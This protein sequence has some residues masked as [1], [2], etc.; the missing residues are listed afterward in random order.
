MRLFLSILFIILIV[1]C[2]ADISGISN[3]GVYWMIYIITV[4]P[5]IV[6]ICNIIIF[7]KT[8]KKQISNKYFFWITQVLS[9]LLVLASLETLKDSY[10][11]EYYSEGYLFTFFSLVILPL[12]F[13]AY[14]LYF[15]LFKNFKFPAKTKY[16]VLA[17]IALG[18]SLSSIIK[19][20]YNCVGQGINL[21]YTGNPFVFKIKYPNDSL[22][23]YY[24][25]VGVALNLVVWVGFIILIWQIA[26]RMFGKNEVLYRTILIGLLMFA[27]INILT[28]YLMIGKGFTTYRN[29]WHFDVDEKAKKWDL[30]C[31]CDVSVLGLNL[32]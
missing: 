15:R 23:Y 26:L 6:W 10:L 20:E 7:I 13:S 32:K 3:V 12:F 24:S 27:T 14:S 2:Y 1:P 25:I 28:N 8:I 21:E 17:Y 11:I 18:I 4:L 5:L 29:Y 19:V 31:E 22:A 9:I 16:L 30:D